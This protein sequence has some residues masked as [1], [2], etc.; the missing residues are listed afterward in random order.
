MWIKVYALQ[1]SIEFKIYFEKQIG[2]FLKIIAQILNS[3]GLFLDQSFFEK[4]AIARTVV[5]NPDVI[6]FVL[7]PD[8]SLS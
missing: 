5:N 3:Y 8:L 7:Y 4:S 1:K 6:T 2:W